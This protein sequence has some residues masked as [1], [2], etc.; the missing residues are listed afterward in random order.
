MVLEYNHHVFNETTETTAVSVKPIYDQAGRT[1]IYSIYSITAYERLSFAAVDDSQAEGEAENASRVEAIIAQLSRPAGILKFE[2]RG[3][4]DLRIN[5][6]PKSDVVWGPKP[7]VIGLETSGGRTVGLTWT[8][9]VAIPNCDD[10]VFKYALMEF[11]FK[12]TFDKDRQGYTTRTVAGFLRI[13]QTRADVNSRKLTD[14]ADAYLESIF[15]PLLPGFR[16]ISG[17]W[18]LDE[19]K[20]RGDFSFVDE[21]MPPNS[22]PIGVIEA[23]SN[24][25]YNAES[26]AK[27]TGTISA[28]YDVARESDPSFAVIAFLQLVKQRMDFAAKMKI[29]AGL[30]L[31]KFP[32]FKPNAGKGVTLVPVKASASEPDIYGRTQ[33]QLSLTYA[34]AGIGFAEVFQNGGLWQ[35][36]RLSAGP[37]WKDWSSSV[38][39][40]MSARGNAKLTFKPNEDAIVDLCG[41]S[42]PKFPGKPAKVGT[43]LNIAPP[44]HTPAGTGHPLANAIVAAFPPP[45]PE[46]SWLHY[47]CH[48]VVHPDT[49]RVV[50]NTLPSSPLAVR[51]SS[52][53]DWNL[54]GAIPGASQ[55]SGA[56]PPLGNIFTANSQSGGETFYQQRT[57]PTLRLTVTGR[58]IR[59]GYPIPVPQVTSV[60]G[61]TP[62]LVGSPFFAQWIVENALVPIV[63]AEWCYQYVFTDDGGVPSSALPVPPTHFLT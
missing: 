41:K 9:E 17:P 32:N 59:A 3:Y 20:C 2:G 6:G 24:H 48:A 56:F 37:S 23:K 57:R 49:G 60:N 52:G 61:E 1:V 47:E 51:P 14:S 34:V 33:V 15:P 27:W 44:P 36:P 39:T 62:I 30:D 25:T 63:R 45:L 10:A 19:S 21:E 12:L 28:T 22:P 4:G 40:A 18:T 13:P 53:G 7:R 11:N 8:V 31:G 58:A 26:L 42:P 50:G 46:S 35:R 16:R 43:P 55:Q 5:V 38:A 54:F 29:G